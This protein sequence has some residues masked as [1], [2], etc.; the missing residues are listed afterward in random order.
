MPRIVFTTAE[1]NSTVELLHV[2]KVHC[3]ELATSVAKTFPDSPLIE[4]LGIYADQATD[5]IAQI[6][7]S[8]A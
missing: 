2:A 7:E 3:L 8:Q 6:T 4:R 1:L 5:L